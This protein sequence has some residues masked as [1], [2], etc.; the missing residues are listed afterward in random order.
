MRYKCIR[1]LH[2]QSGCTYSFLPIT[3]HASITRLPIFFSKVLFFREITIPYSPRHKSYLP[4]LHLLEDKCIHSIWSVLFSCV[5]LS[6][7]YTNSENLGLKVVVIVILFPI[8]LEILTN[9]HS[10]S[11]K[12]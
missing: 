11:S 3:A 6:T 4:S 2:H 9:I 8:I 7:K 12:I 10:I 1:L 5:E